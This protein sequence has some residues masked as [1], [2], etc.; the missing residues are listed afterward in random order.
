MKYNTHWSGA[1]IKMYVREGKDEYC[2]IKQKDGA[3]VGV[4]CMETEQ[5][6]RAIK[7]KPRREKGSFIF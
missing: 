2:T 1:L 7:T 4:G 5:K 6:P 3:V